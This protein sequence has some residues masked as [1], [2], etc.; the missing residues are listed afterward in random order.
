M[1]RSDFIVMW[2]SVALAAAVMYAAVAIADPTL[3][4]WPSTQ[5]E[6]QQQLSDTADRSK[7]ENQQF[8]DD[9]RKDTTNDRLRDI[10]DAIIFNGEE[11]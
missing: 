3:N 8:L 1:R 2:S 4:L 9:V 6:A 11:R 7:A 5:A 10:E